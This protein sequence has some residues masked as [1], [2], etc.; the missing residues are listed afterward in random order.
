MHTV[1]GHAIRWHCDRAA[2]RYSFHWN[3]QR[4]AL[5]MFGQ[6][7]V[8]KAMHRA[9]E[10][11]KYTRQGTVFVGWTEYYLISVLLYHDCVTWWIGTPY[12]MFFRVRGL[13]S[14]NKQAWTTL[15]SAHLGGT[16]G[17]RSGTKVNCA[18]VIDFIETTK[19]I[20]NRQMGRKP[21]SCEMMLLVWS[22]TK[23]SRTKR[24]PWRASL[25]LYIRCR[26]FIYREA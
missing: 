21:S 23:S 9:K 4:T 16:H 3:P 17:H 14:M 15:K 10:T 2:Q 22:R 25:P 20:W 26:A 6:F 18:I 13:E 12:L 7:G 11:L 5:K 1:G 8:G 19:N 24:A